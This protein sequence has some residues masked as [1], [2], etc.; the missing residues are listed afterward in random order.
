VTGWR[1]QGSSNRGGTLP[2]SGVEEEV[3]EV[4]SKN[5]DSCFLL[6]TCLAYS[7]TLK[8]EAVCSFTGTYCFDFAAISHS[9]RGRAVHAM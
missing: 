6:G 7:S 1:R 2:R 8:M 3:K 5:K 9:V 4:T